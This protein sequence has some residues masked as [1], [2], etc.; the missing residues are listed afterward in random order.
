MLNS[1]QN[2]V[3]SFHSVVFRIRIKC[4]SWIALV[5]LLKPKYP[6]CNIADLLYRNVYLKNLTQKYCDQLKVKCTLRWKYENN[7][8]NKLILHLPNFN[9]DAMPRTTAIGCLRQN[10]WSC[11]LNACFLFSRWTEGVGGKSCSLVKRCGGQSGGAGG[12]ASCVNIEQ[13]PGASLQLDFLNKQKR[14]NHI[15][16]S[17]SFSMDFESQFY[18]CE[19]KSVIKKVLFSVFFA[20]ERKL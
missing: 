11:G 12:G 7:Q 6:E 9:A 10:S 14:R 5:N 20:V 18:I 19:M 8:D 13:A 16:P 17:V 3:S 1:I 15:S 4:C 2:S